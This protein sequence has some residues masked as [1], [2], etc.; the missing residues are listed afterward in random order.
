MKRKSETSRKYALRHTEK[1]SI[2]EDCGPECDVTTGVCNEC[3]EWQKLSSNP[4]KE[5]KEPDA[6][7]QDAS[8]P[9]D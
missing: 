7:K 4:I 8:T 6:E 9:E 2:L 5:D 3:L 1:K